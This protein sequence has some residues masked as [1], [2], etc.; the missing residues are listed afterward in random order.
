MVTELVSE[1][2]FDVYEEYT[3]T[4]DDIF[5]YRKEQVDYYINEKEEEHRRE[6]DLLIFEIERLKKELAGEKASHENSLRF[7]VILKNER[8]KAN[9]ELTLANARIITL[10]RSK[11]RNRELYKELAE[12]LETCEGSNRYLLKE[13]ERLEKELRNAINEKEE[14][15][16]KYNAEIRVYNH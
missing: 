3:K 10:E 2:C 15:K 5:V 16:R 8:D 14:W 1:D 11:E 9:E 6:V 4:G 12:Q 7:Q 13:K